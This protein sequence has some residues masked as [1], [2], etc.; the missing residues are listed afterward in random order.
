MLCSKSFPRLLSVLITTST[1]QIFTSIWTSG[2]CSG[3][4]RAG[5]ILLSPLTPSCNILPNFSH[6]HL[7]LLHDRAGGRVGD[8]QCDC[9]LVV[10]NLWTWM[11][12]SKPRPAL[13]SWK[14]HL[15]Q[16]FRGLG[17][18][19]GRSYA[20]EWREISCFGALNRPQIPLFFSQSPSH[21]RS[22]DWAE[23]LRI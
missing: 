3:T 9:M 12:R 4:C 21:L 18:S 15:M 14:E 7:F 6:I 11:L 19:Q 10:S 5:H 17:G 22:I 8:W 1:Y 23:T 2:H 16:F 20:G 13:P